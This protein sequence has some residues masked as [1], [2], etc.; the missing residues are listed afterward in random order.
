MFL[1][2]RLFRHSTPRTQPPLHRAIPPKTLLIFRPTVQQLGLRQD[3]P[4]TKEIGGIHR[5][6]SFLPTNAVW[7][8]HLDLSWR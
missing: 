7:M 4:F 6:V 8:L 3:C 2:R 1:Y 5:D